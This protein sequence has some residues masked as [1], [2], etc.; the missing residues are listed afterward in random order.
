MWCGVYGAMWCGVYGA[1]WCGLY[2]AMWCGAYGA[3]WCGLY[4]AMWCGLYGA[5]DLVCR[6]PSWYRG[7]CLVYTHPTSLLP[8]PPPLSSYL[9]RGIT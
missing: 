9:R 4:G 2:G 5:M 7:M 1:M 8:I 6:Q 3:M